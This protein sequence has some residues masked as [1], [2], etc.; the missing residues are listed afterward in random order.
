MR[1]APR[2]TTHD[3][4]H[5]A[6]TARRASPRAQRVCGDEVVDGVFHVRAAALGT[7]D[8]DQ[9]L[10]RNVSAH[11]IFEEA[12][13]S[14]TEPLERRLSAELPDGELQTPLGKAPVNHVRCGRRYFWLT[15]D[16]TLFLLLF[17]LVPP[18]VVMK[19]VLDGMAEAELDGLDG[20]DVLQA[21]GALRCHGVLVQEAYA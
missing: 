3:S 7:G 16:A 14:S 11:E 8:A 13:A 17:G 10:L 2:L 20:Q 12:F 21:H 18:A 6:I 9:L 1:D 19:N 4:A 15:A 5:G